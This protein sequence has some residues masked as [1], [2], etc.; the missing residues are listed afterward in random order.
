MVVE[1]N[2]NYHDL[3]H[4]LLFFLLYPYLRALV[5]T[6]MKTMSSRVL[7]SD[8]NEKAL[9]EVMINIDSNECEEKSGTQDYGCGDEDVCPIC[10]EAWTSGGKHQI[11]YE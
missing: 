6:V 3:L 4:G 9:Q 5:V 7:S 2:L 1:V 10:F 11:W 8:A